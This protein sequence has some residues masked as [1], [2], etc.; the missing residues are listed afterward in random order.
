MMM[1]KTEERRESGGNC[2]TWP[3]RSDFI[4]SE[5]RER[6]LRSKGVRKGARGA[7]AVM[8]QWRRR[9]RAFKL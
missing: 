2:P 1:N 3:R 4:G 5:E 9:D 7:D 8:H 6:G